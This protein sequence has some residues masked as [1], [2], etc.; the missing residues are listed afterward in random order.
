MAYE[1]E[2]RM[3]E[4]A[5]KGIRPISSIADFF[6]GGLS[7]DDAH[8]ICEGNIQRRLEEGER[9]VGYKVGLTNIAAREKMGMPDSFYGYLLESMLLESGCELRMDAFI[10]PKIESE[11]CFKLA[12]DIQ[13]KGLTVDDVVNATEAVSASFEIC[14]ARIKGWACRYSDYF[15]DNGLACRVVLAGTWHPVK[16]VDLRNETVQLHRNGEKIAGGRG[17][18]CMGHPAKAVAWLAGKLADRGKGLKAGQIVMTG[19]LT[20]ITPMERGVAY[21]SRFLTL[22]SVRI[23]TV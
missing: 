12:K 8:L 17:E 19:T 22:G 16:D 13:G 18:L 5:E 6:P 20:P 4:Q 15:A 23:T 10:E 14:D 2:M 9:I 21:L 1:N 11:I 3:L 7:V